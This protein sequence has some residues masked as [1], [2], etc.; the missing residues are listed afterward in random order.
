MTKSLTLLWSMIALAGLLVSGCNKDQVI[1]DDD[2]PP[3]GVTNEQDAIKYYAENDEFVRN[4]EQTFTDE[5][6]QPMGNGAFGMIEAEITPL[7][8]GRFVTSVTTTVT[9]TVQPGDSIAIA[10]VHKDISGDF[11]ILAINGAGDTVLIVKAF[12]DQSDRNVIFKRVN[13]DV[14][15]FWRNWVPVATS[16]VEGGTNPQPAGHE[17]NL[18]KLQVFL[19]NGDTITVTDPTSFY[20][21]YRWLRLFGGGAHDVPELEANH[22]I[23]L[24]ATVVSA[25][26]DTDLVALRYGLGLFKRRFRMQMVSEVDNGNGTWTR[27]YSTTGVN[28]TVPLH[29]GFFHMGVDAATRTTLFDDVAPYSVSWWGVPYRVF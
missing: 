15:R 10:H 5:D 7:R 29:R 1:V 23:V 22:R 28:A 3:P 26:P 17:I 24:E 16:L 2:T 25:S 21:R 8:F 19:P 9:V 12:V 4:D 11:K 27:V 18:V 14:R 6:I 13:R 20:L